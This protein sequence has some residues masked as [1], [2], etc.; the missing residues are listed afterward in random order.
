MDIK[1]KIIASDDGQSGFRYLI[2]S[3]FLAVLCFFIVLNTISKPNENKTQDILENVRDEFSGK[4]FLRRIKVFQEKKHKGGEDLQF[5]GIKELV[6]NYLSQNNYI[7]KPQYSDFGK[8]LEI[9]I[10][11]THFYTSKSSIFPKNSAV[12]FVKQ[13]GEILKDSA[14]VEDYNM[15]VIS[16]YTKGDS[17]SLD[18]AARRQSTLTNILL[19]AS[20]YKARIEDYLAPYDEGETGHDK[21]KLVL[22][23]DEN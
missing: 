10:D 1:R 8:F 2:V 14:K 4:N 22:E 19:K 3:L 17:H 23:V 13:L 5:F 15:T 6:K 12:S 21:V 7:S 16:P 20:D 11:K 18:L 9:N